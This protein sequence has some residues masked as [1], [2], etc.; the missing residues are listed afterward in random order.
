MKRVSRVLGIL[1]VG[2]LLAGCASDYTK[3]YQPFPKPPPTATQPLPYTG[4]VRVIHSSGNF[5][6]DKRNLFEEGYGP[7]G[8]SSFI[9][10]QRDEKQAI[11]QAKTVGAAVVVLAAKY[12]STATGAVPITTPTT[13]TTYS[14]GTVNTYGAGGSAFGNYNGTST[15]YGTQTT[16]IPY[17]VDRYDQAAVFFAPL[18][19]KGLGVMLHDLT[20]EQKRQIGSNKGASI[21]S[22]RKGSPAFNADIIPGDILIMLNGLA[23][24]DVASA[25]AM[26]VGARGTTVDIS[27]QRDGNQIKKSVLIPS[28][29]W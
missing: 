25:S 15:T 24:D 1:F 27:L 6:D 26:L 18:E 17:S 7:I 14:S 4:D 19:R 29:D 13:Q 11:S 22:I 3:F 5:E 21:A 28:G 8:V 10:P 2:T 20:P 12:Q 23:V 9:A 16:Y